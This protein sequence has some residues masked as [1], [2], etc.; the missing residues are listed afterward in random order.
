MGRVWHGPTVADRREVATIGDIIE[1][2]MFQTGVLAPAEPAGP[3][4]VAQASAG[5]STTRLG[6]RCPKC[7]QLGR[8]REARCLNCV[9][10]D[11]S[12]ADGRDWLGS[13]TKS[14]Q[15]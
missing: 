12:V 1:R 4:T 8:V 3:K 2:H 7:S 5:A 11:P 14:Q 6:P 13:G 9:H 15:S 10:C